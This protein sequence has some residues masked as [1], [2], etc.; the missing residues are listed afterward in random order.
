[1][2]PTPPEPRPVAPGSATFAFICG[3]P[4][5]VLAVALVGCVAVGCRFVEVRA[6]ASWWQ[7]SVGQLPRLGNRSLAPLTLVVESG[8]T[9]LCQA[10]A[11]FLMLQAAATGRLAWR[12]LGRALLTRWRTLAHLSAI[13]GACSSLSLLA[14]AALATADPQG[15]GAISHP[16]AF[17]PML[18]LAAGMVYVGLRCFVAAPVAMVEGTTAVDSLLVSWRRQRGRLLSTFFAAL[19]VALP[20]TLAQVVALWALGAERFVAFADPATPAGAIVGC[21]VALFSAPA[22]F[23]P[24]V[25]YIVTR[26]RQAAPASAKERPAAAA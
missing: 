13:Y 3:F 5:A 18:C 26:P 6:A 17:L 22:A 8:L 9:L 10:A 21:A 7:E 23:L 16:G 25:V 24:G 2:Q 15:G 1:M 12:Q 11:A 14:V 19:F 4:A 20:G